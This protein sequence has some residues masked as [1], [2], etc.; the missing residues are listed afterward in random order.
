[1]KKKWLFIVPI[2]LMLACNALT[3]PRSTPTPEIVF[4][5]PVLVTPTSVESLPTEGA[6]TGGGSFSAIIA[7]SAPTSFFLLGGAQNGEWLSAEIVAPQLSGG[8][9]YQLYDV[10]GPSGLTEGEV[11]LP[12]QICPLY[13]V[14]TDSGLF[15]G[16]TVG[17]TGNWDVTPRLTEEHPTDTPVYI[18][19]LRDWLVRQNI[20]DPVVEISQIL[21]VD[22]E[23]DGI[24]EVL[25]SASHF[26]EP[27]GHDVTAGDYSLVLMR[28]VAGDTVATVPLVADYY[29]QNVELQY[30]LTYNGLL[31]ADLNND[32][33]LEVV[34][35]VERWEGSGI[36]VF[37]IDRTNVRT[38]FDVLCGL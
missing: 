24:D 35:G 14:A 15:D 10:D 30:P 28:K 31:V 38:V 34:V 2:A 26:A 8:E 32:G 21:R 33:A 22:L 23:G 3:F 19:A 1:M 13:W 20:S 12:D 17:V 7:R 37:E 16:L 6:Q 29:Y 11:P 18:E 9:M 5:S 25:I 4:P 27:T 36:K